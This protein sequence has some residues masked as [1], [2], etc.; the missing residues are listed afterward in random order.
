MIG[1]FGKV[2]FVTNDKR[3]LTFQ[4]FKRDSTVRSEK[5]AIIGKK[6]AKEFLGAELD[7][8]SFTIQLSAAHGVKPRE[9][10]EKWLRMSRAGLAFPLVIG[11]RALGMDKWT[12]ES[13]SQAWDVV[14]NRGELYSCKVDI[15]LEEYIEEL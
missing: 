3:I 1:Y 10:A 5:H 8:I 12:V 13:V 15:T 2:K 4:D 7:T 14:F 6:P 9:E 11:T